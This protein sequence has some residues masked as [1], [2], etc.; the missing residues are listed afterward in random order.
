MQCIK[1][2]KPMKRREAIK[3][4]GKASLIPVAA[5]SPLYYQNNQENAERVMRIAHLTDMHMDDVHQ[6][7]RRLAKTLQVL[8][9]I[10]DMPD[11]IFNGGDTIM[12]A[13]AR[14][15]DEADKQ[16]KLWQKVIKEECDLE[17]IHCIGNHDVWGGGSKNDPLYGKKYAMEKMQIPQ[18]YYRFER[19]GWQ[20][21]VLDSTHTINGEW[22]TAKL[23]EEQYEWLAQELTKIPSGN[24]VMV[25]SHI[26]I[27]TATAFYESVKKENSWEVPGSWMHL[28]YNR[29]K[30]LFSQHK[31]V[32][33]CISGH[34]HLLDYVEYNHVVYLCNGAVSGNWWSDKF[35]HETEAGFALIDLYADGTFKREYVTNIW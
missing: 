23:D 16:W 31:N 27:L 14:K 30:N 20:F 28:D 17:I 4:L 12:D 10:D 24:P 34:M 19:N 29:I 2:L 8:Q 6:A 13:L 3:N 7:P 18:R 26:P 25:V 1:H 5:Y 33:L 32:K 15:K 9:S 35:Y 21:I 11:I 22:Y